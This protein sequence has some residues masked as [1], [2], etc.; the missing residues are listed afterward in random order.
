VNVCIVGYGMMGG[1]HS[2]ALKDTDAVLHTLVGRRADAAH[3]FAGRYGYKKWTTSLEQALADPDIDIVILANPSD[4]HAETAM[5]SVLAGKPTLVE[6][7]LAMNLADGEKIVRT[8]R[9]LNVTLGVVHPMRVRSEMVALKERLLAGKEQVRQV[10]GRFYIYRL[11]NV[12]ATGYRRSWTDNLLWHHINHLVDFGMWMLDAPVRR[13]SSFM[14]PPDK[15]TGI[16]MDLSLG[17]ETERDQSFVCTGSYYGHER[18]FETFVLTDKDSYRLEIFS[19]I[20]TTGAGPQPVIEEK[21]NCM[22][23]TRDFVNAVREGREPV[24]PG[25]AVLP[26]LRVLQQVQDAWDAIHGV[27]SIPGRELMEQRT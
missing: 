10:C 20:M 22:Q 24:V 27:Q 15:H 17:V 5:A 4:Q 14:P 16:P 7:P 12:G 23:L 11:E 1:W 19:S 18:L 3:E 8:A 25:E 2:D 9:D 26:A 6:I 13:V 21:A